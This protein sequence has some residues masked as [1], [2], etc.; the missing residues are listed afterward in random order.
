[1]KRV[2]LL[3]RVNS[4]FGLLR[5][6][7]CRRRQ[8]NGLGALVFFRED[9]EISRRRIDC[10]YWSVGRLR[11]C[12]RQL[13]EY[14]EVVYRWAREAV[15]SDSLPVVLFTPGERPNTITVAFHTMTSNQN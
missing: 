8:E 11:D 15:E 1:M 13:D 14:D 6:Y 3:D 7:T 4:N 12:L 9:A 2:C 10:E 5:T